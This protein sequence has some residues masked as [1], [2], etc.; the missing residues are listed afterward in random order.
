M[1]FMVY[2]S[3]FCIPLLLFYMIAYGLLTKTDIYKEFTE[4]AKDGFQVTF[5]ILPTLIGLMTGVGMLR[6]SGFLEMLS[7][8]LKPVAEV[9]LFPAELVPLVVVKLFSS[10]AAT[11]LVL[12]IFKEFGPDSYLGKVTSLI[13]S[14]TETVF[15]TMSVYFMAAGVKKTRYTLAGALTATAVGVAVSTILGGR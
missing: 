5:G 6:A 8:L 13:C 4:G 7:G 12:D 15:Y 1:K 2:L 11:G 9:F 3:D 10:S 14:S